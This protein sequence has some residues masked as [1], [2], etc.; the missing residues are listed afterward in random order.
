MD[1]TQ[2]TITRTLVSKLNILEASKY[3]NLENGDEKLSDILY[4]RK[5]LSMQLELHIPSNP[6]EQTGT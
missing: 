2:G 1:K 5:L 4:C 6:R 3:G